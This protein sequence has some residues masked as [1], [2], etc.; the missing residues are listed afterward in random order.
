MDSSSSGSGTWSLRHSI[1][2]SSSSSSASSASSNSLSPSTR[3]R[4]SASAHNRHQRG[5]SGYLPRRPPPPPIETLTD[6]Y[7]NLSCSSPNNLQQP[8]SPPSF[9]T[10][11]TPPRPPIVKSTR[12]KQPSFDLSVF[13]KILSAPDKILIPHSIPDIS[14][15]TDNNDSIEETIQRA[16][17]A[18]SIKKLLTKSSAGNLAAVGIGIG[19]GGGLYSSIEPPPPPAPSKEH[20]HTPT[21]GSPL[22][23]GHGPHGVVYAVRKNTGTLGRRR[24]R[25]N[26][27]VSV[28]E[29]DWSLA[30]VTL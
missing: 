8:S 20:Y 21:V 16:I 11:F 6:Y 25:S 1:C 3:H 24:Q 17:K 23:H 27:A 7:N 30:G 28:Q 15:T 12:S 9:L 2:S 13:D 14:T 10:Q 5:G 19:I 26:S 18:E 22:H 4:S 29:C